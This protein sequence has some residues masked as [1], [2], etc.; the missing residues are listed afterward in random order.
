[1]DAETENKISMYL[2]VRDFLKIYET[3]LAANIAI[4]ALSISFNAMIDNFFNSAGAAGTNSKGYTEAKKKSREVLRD[5]CKL[6]SAALFAYWNHN[7]LE[8]T[9]DAR[10]YLQRAL[11]RASGDTLY[12]RATEL[13]H[14]A[15][16]VKALLAPYN[17]TPAAVDALLTHKNQFLSEDKQ[18]RTMLKT[19][20]QARK[21]MLDHLRQGK[22]ILQAL[23]I[24]VHT[25]ASTHKALYLEYRTARSVD[26]MRG[27][28]KKKKETDV[29]QT[30][31]P[32]PN[33]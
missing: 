12:T 30:P 33:S 1:M 7:N 16:P 15:D 9:L 31:E 10:S 11:R 17:C 19:R 20:A 24:H 2:K 8:A 29:A 6:V 5:S 14:A 28:R 23:D 32:L 4:P 22:T 13:H 25:F 26:N 18:P 27:K 21:A 3:T